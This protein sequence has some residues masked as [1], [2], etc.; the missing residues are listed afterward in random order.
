MAN[1]Y[2]GKDVEEF[3]FGEGSYEQTE[4]TTTVEKNETVEESF[5]ITDEEMNQ[6]VMECLDEPEVACYRIALENEQNYNMVMNAMMTREFSVLE[7][8]GEEMV[9]EAANVKGF[10]AN[11][12]K[13][14]A[15]FWQKVQGMFKAAMSRI[16]DFV[17]SNGKFVKKY[18]GQDMKKPEKEKK[19]MGY[20][21]TTNEPGFE[22]VADIISKNVAKTDIE[23]DSA[24]A[25]TYVENFKANFSGLKDRMRYAAVYD[26]DGGHLNDS[27]FIKAARVQ[28]YGAEKKKEVELPAFGELLSILEGASIAKG[29]VKS[30]YKSCENTIKALR[31]DVKRTESGLLKSLGLANSTSV[32]KVAK[33]LTDSINASLGIMSRT[34]SLWIG[35]VDAQCRQARAM[36]AFYV[37]NQPAEKKE[38][39]AKNESAIDDLG[40]V[41][42]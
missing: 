33:C 32:M 2:M 31:S 28:F 16:Q 5:E 21:F 17:S 27:D 24:K 20:D 42:I 37:A 38:K 19:F 12:Q 41:L 6:G 40:I 13:V 34:L 35:S 25:N 15:N 11:I 39:E 14:I 30:T 3:I 18:K 10:F 9:Y 26:K 36:A 23:R 1:V 4:E 8:T 7:S 29:R 22:K